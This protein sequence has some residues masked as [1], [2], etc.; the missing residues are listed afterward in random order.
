VRN[1][2]V[3]GGTRGIGLGIAVRLASEGYRVIAVARSEPDEFTA[4]RYACEKA[5]VG[6]LAFMACDLNDLEALRPLVAAISERFGGWYG[7]VN[8]AGLGTPG[9]L[10]TMP[11]DAVEALLRLNVTSPIVLT[12]FAVRKMMAKGEGGR[13]VNLSSVVAGGGFSGLSVYAATKAALQGFSRSL[14][15]ELGPLGI[16]VN[17]VAPGFVATSM[18]GELDNA[19]LDKIVRRSALRRLAQPDDVAAAVSYLLSDGAR[20]VTGTTLTVD[21]GGTA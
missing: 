15:R 12:K 16:T 6:E 4:Q 20:N 21:A 8:N 5:G 17:C 1:V 11:V 7:L 18:T 13:I 10:A 3:T 14:A 2:V 9:V 19:A